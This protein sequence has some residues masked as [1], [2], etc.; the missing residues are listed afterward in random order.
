MLFFLIVTFIFLGIGRS[1]YYLWK[2]VVSK[3]SF[4]SLS[5]LALL[6]TVYVT[7][8]L[9][10]GLL[11]IVFESTGFNILHEHG[12]PLG[13][14]SLHL[15]EVCLYFSTITLLSVGY[16]DI[17]PIEMGR[18]IAMIEALIGYVMPA[19]FIFHSILEKED[20]T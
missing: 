4:F 19:A 5:N 2:T 10:F 3:S 20:N 1:I 13:P 12:E 17:I 15:I 9:G 14:P 6:I 18:W 8:L 16:G 11:Y 7:I